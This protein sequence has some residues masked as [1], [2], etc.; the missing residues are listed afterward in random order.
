LPG[1]SSD[2]HV[3]KKGFESESKLSANWIASKG[4]EDARIN[5]EY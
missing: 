2:G 4:N 1:N 5:N 3:S